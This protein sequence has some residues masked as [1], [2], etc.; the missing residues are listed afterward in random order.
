MSYC[1]RPVPRDLLP[2]GHDWL[3]LREHGGGDLHLV[4]ADDVGGLEL[5]RE[6]L[7][8]IISNVAEHKKL[9]VAS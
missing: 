1:V 2:K 8:V 7:E 5:P 6:A 4:L 9:R 3:F